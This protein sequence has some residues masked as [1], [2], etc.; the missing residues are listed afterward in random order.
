MDAGSGERPAVMVPAA[1]SIKEAHPMLVPA[2]LAR[3][4]EELEQPYADYTAHVSPDSMAIAHAT[5][6]YILWLCRVLRPASVCDFGS[7]FTSY[8]LRYYGECEVVSVDDHPDWIG[9]TSKYLERM[10]YAPDGLMMF[11][12]YM[13]TDLQHD[14][15][16]YDFS[17]GNVREANFGMALDRLISE[18]VAVFDDAQHGG[19]QARMLEE[20]AARRFDLCSAHEFT[21]DRY[22][23]FAAVA[24]KGA[25]SR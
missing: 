25:W 3:E 11:D 8:V 17:N 13:R 5:S 12:E 10:G 20:C 24:V 21:K 18:G 9:W 23:R 19:H 15:I 6:A 7:G 14:L 22:G 16:V 1:M 2:S 4:I